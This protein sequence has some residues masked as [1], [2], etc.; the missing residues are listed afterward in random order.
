MISSKLQKLGISVV[1]ARNP[2]LLFVPGV[3]NVQVSKGEEIE[4]IFEAIYE[5]GF[6]DGIEKGKKQKSNQILELLTDKI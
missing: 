6:K 1:Q 3:G 2:R 5:N 4:D